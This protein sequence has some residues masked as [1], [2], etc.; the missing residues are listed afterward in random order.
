MF[1]KYIGDEGDNKPKVGEVYYLTIWNKGERLDGMIV[2][3][4]LDN[5]DFILWSKTYVSYSDFK[6]DW[7]AIFV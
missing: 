6:E 5:H 7:D 2:A 1:Y 3:T 4:I